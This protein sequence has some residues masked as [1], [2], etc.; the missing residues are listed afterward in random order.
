M[1][2]RRRSPSGRLP[3]AAWSR[4]RRLAL[5]RDDW[6]CK[7][8]SPA[9]LEVHHVRPVAEGGEPFALANLA[10]LCRECLPIG[11]LG[12]EAARVAPAP[13]GGRMRRG[14]VYKKHRTAGWILTWLVDPAPGRRGVVASFYFSCHDCQPG[15]FGALREH[16]EFVEVDPTPAKGARARRV[17][18]VD[19]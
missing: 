14:Q 3:W 7:C 1:L 18:R 5:D 19:R 15:E 8:G 17:R 9:D 2:S 13:G 10:T 4:A 16:V 12:S 11:S 6:R